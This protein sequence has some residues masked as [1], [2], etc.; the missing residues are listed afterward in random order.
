MNTCENL[1]HFSPAARRVL[2]VDDNTDMAMSLSMLL[3]TLGY[4][5]RTAM[6]GAQAVDVSASFDPQIAISDICMPGMD[7]FDLARTLRQSKGSDINLIALSAN[8]QPAFRAEAKDAG[9]NSFQVKPVDLE[10]L[11]TLIESI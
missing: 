4:D 11:L 7:G 10:A 6:N 5:V 3:L 8:D 2:V 1:P 9:F